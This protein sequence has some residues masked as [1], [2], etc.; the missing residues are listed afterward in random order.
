MCCSGV[1]REPAGHAGGRIKRPS[2]LRGEKQRQAPE[3]IYKTECFFVF[4]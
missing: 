3:V 2:Y 4:L 1:S